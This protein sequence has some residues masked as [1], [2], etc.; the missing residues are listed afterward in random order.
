M[1]PEVSLNRATRAGRLVRAGH[2]MALG[3]GREGMHDVG[4]QLKRHAGQDGHA[5]F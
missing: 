3:E 5:G 2:F 4:Q 1:W